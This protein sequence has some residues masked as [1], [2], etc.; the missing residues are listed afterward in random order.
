MTTQQSGCE[1][2]AGS[3]TVRKTTKDRPYHYTISG[4]DNV[5]LVGIDVEECEACKIQEP[6]IP[7]LP[8]LHQ[9][10][11]KELLRKEEL[12]AGN[13]IRFLRKNAGIPAKRFAALI[14]QSPEHLSRV[15]NGKT[16]N[17]GP[18]ADKLARAVISAANESEDVRKLLLE[19]ADGHINAKQTVYSLEE[20]HWKLAA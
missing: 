13:E 8:E 15:E 16:E 20:D 14:Q 17:L 3:I 9:I 18:T 7:K 5:F 12:L 1:S 4:L 2:C 6:I 11:A 10:I 19:I